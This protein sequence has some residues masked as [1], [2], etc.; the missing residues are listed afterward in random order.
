MILQMRNDLNTEAGAASQKSNTWNCA[1]ENRPAH[2][3]SCSQSKPHEDTFVRFNRVRILR[4]MDE[5]CA[6]AIAARA[7]CLTGPAH[8]VR[9]EAKRTTTSRQRFGHIAEI[10]AR[11]SPAKNE[12]SA[13]SIEPLRRNSRGVV[14]CSAGTGG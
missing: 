6:A 10:G 3:T 8:T 7:R 11:R 12:L 5:F 4:R 9:S 2:N 14:F 1:P 13:L